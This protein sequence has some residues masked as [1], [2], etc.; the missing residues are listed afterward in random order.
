MKA[1]G[2]WILCEMIKA[3]KVLVAIYSIFNY[4]FSHIEAV[5]DS[6]VKTISQL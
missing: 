3:P 6:A 5:P 2:E 1:A 4:L